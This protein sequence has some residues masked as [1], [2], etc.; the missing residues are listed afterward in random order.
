MSTQQATKGAAISRGPSIR[1][2]DRPMFV[3]GAEYYP[4]SY[5]TAPQALFLVN[6]DTGLSN[7]LCIIGAGR[8]DHIELYRMDKSTLIYSANDRLEYM[9]LQIYT[10][11]IGLEDSEPFLKGDGY[12]EIARLS[13]VNRIKM[14][15]EYM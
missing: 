6:E 10:P 7:Q 3:S 14:M 1:R 12:D 8:T 2:E 13:P 9:G 11:G 5:Y 15:L 4:T